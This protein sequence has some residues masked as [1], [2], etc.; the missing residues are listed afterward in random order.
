MI[1]IDGLTIQIGSFRLDPVDLHVAGAEYVVLLGP[2]GVGKTMLLRCLAGLICPRS[3]RIHIN[4]RD[5]TGLPPRDRYVGYVPQDY[6]LFPHLS[7]QE[8]VTFGLRARGTGRHEAR[9]RI[10]PLAEL[11]GIEPL[12]GRS[13]GGLSGGEQQKVALARALAPEPHV[14]LLDEPVSAIDVEHRYRLYRELRRIQQELRVA[15]IHVTH[16]LD[17]A[18]AVADRAG[19]ILDG[20]L[21]QVAPPDDLLRRPRTEAV[22][23]FVRVG[24]IFRAEAAPTPEG[25]TVLSFPAGH[26]R[27]RGTHRGPVTFVVRPNDLRVLPAGQR[28]D[29]AVPA[30]LTAVT[31]RAAYTRL[32]F[33][34]VVPI[35]V[36]VTAQPPG[37]PWTLQQTH[38]LL[39]PPDALHVLD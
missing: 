26:V 32:R 18:L 29:N 38:Q 22:A 3:G 6:G 14:L 12:L 33:D 39:F 36:Y 8:N 30:T 1:R 25:D 23:R 34:A 11:L 4:G 10:A 2:N 9:E 24:N 19:I 21:A 20:R 15:T 31:H 35:T 37:A 13:V 17:E 5:V 16:S 7:V 28:V 27:C